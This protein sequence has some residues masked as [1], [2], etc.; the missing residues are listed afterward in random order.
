[1][2]IKNFTKRIFLSK[3][4]LKKS[5]WINLFFLFFGLLGYYFEYYLLT[6]YSIVH[7]F[8]LFGRYSSKD[9]N[10]KAENFKKDQITIRDHYLKDFKVFY[11]L[12]YI[13]RLI[14][15]LFYFYFFSLDVG[16]M[17]DFANLFYGISYIFI[18]VGFIDLGITW[19]IILYKNHPII[20]TITNLC[21][22]G[23]TKGLPLMGALHISSNVPFISPNPVSN[24]YHKYSPL[25]RGYGAWSSI[26]LVEIDYLKSHLGKKFDYTEVIDT[27]R[28]VDP[29]K[30]K[31]YAKNNSIDIK[32]FLD[33]TINTPKKP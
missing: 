26:N 7:F 31:D 25:G 6:F 30:L 33:S 11:Y 27:N 5:D 3:S 28:M 1:M 14:T 2:N 4:N 13:I 24:G 23:A 19:Y 22:H 29:T 21:Y 32:T 18:I 8:V 17:N 16:N 20:E 10:V 15:V 9:F 12:V